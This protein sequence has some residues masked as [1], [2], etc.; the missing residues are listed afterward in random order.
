MPNWVFNY[1]TVSGE[2]D[3]VNE[4]KSQLN[5]PFEQSFWNYMTDTQETEL[6]ENPIFSFWNIKKPSDDVLDEYFAKQPKVRSEL[7]LN[8]PNWWADIEE[9]RKISNHWYDWNITHWG[10]KWDAKEP[11]IYEE[12]IVGNNKTIMYKFDTAWAPPLYAIELLAQ[13]YPDL[14]ITIEYEE[15]QGWGGN[16]TWN[17]GEITEQEDWDIPSSHADMKS[18]G[19]VCDCE[20]GPEYAY[21]DCGFENEGYTWNK[22]EKI[23]QK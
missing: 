11:E 4:V 12:E 3:I 5:K 15:E 7:A 8:D 18:R 1:V 21:E 14:H 2:L 13:Q 23:W 10:C 16:V 6:T 19:R 17:N 20:A 9:K 22:E